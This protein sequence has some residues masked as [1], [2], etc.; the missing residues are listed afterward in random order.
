MNQLPLFDVPLADASDAVTDAAG[1]LVET[2]AEQIEGLPDVID[3]EAGRPY[4]LMAGMYVGYGKNFI[5]LVRFFLGCVSVRVRQHAAWGSDPM[6]SL[7]D[8][9]NLSAWTVRLYARCA[10]HAEQNV[11]TFYAFLTEG[12]TDKTQ[13]DLSDWCRLDTDETYTKSARSRDR[14]SRL[15]RAG[16]TIGKVLDETD[17]PDERASGVLGT[18]AVMGVDVNLHGVSLYPPV[19]ETDDEDNPLAAY[20]R[21]VEADRDLLA[22]LLATPEV[23]HIRA[24]LDWSLAIARDL[25]AEHVPEGESDES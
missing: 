2:L 14:M 24:V 19:P 8:A 13:D 3:V 9:W 5:H 10:R 25:W 12:G 23:D 11:R 16:R 4:A 18:A 6:Q 20:T 15:E 1:T 22:S 7:A 17:D 21:A